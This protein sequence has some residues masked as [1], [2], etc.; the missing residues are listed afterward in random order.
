MAKAV[1][2]KEVIVISVCKDREMFNHFYG[3]DS[4]L[5]SVMIMEWSC[6]YLDPS[7]L[8]EWPCLGLIFCEIV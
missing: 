2:G 5:C 1:I 7:R 8:Q 3:L 6:Y 4:I